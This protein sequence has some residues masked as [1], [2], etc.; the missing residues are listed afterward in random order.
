[1][2]SRLR[3]TGGSSLAVPIPV[4]RERRPQKQMIWPH[5]ARVVAVV[6]DEQ[7]SRYRTEVQLPGEAMGQ[8]IITPLGVFED[9]Y[10]PVSMFQRGG[11]L[12]AAITYLDMPPEAILQ[13]LSLISVRACATT[14][15]PI[16]TTRTVVLRWGDQHAAPMA[17]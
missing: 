9:P 5:T 17:R 13:P 16:A 3:A 12:P 10:P 11:P 8:Q 1:M 6:A 15:S 2:F 4:V 7:A 14:V